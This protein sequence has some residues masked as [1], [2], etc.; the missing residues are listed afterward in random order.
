MTS[1]RPDLWY[2]FYCREGP[3]N[4]NVHDLCP[5]CSQRRTAYCTLEFSGG[6]DSDRL[7]PQAQPAPDDKVIEENPLR[8]ATHEADDVTTQKQFSP[9]VIHK[10]QDEPIRK[11]NASSDLEHLQSSSGWGVSQAQAHSSPPQPQRK[12]KWMPTEHGTKSAPTPV[13]NQTKDSGRQGNLLV[14]SL[15]GQISTQSMPEN[16]PFNR[17]NLTSED[18]VTSPARLPGQSSFLVETLEDATRPRRRP[19]SPDSR[20]RIAYIK[21]NGG[22]CPHCKKKKKLVSCIMKETLYLPLTRRLVYSPSPGA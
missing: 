2:C 21:N 6:H 11:Q 12:S 5:I 17:E 22:S 10:H 18:P 7:D 9:S 19:H 14:G 16:D 8:S 20:A 1:P 13:G 15:F 3:L 4:I